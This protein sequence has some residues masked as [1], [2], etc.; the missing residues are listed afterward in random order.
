MKAQLVNL[1]KEYHAKLAALEKKNEPK[2]LEAKPRIKELAN[3]LHMYE[4]ENE[5]PKGV[6]V[7]ES[8]GMC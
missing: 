2:M 6:L 4:S 8:P 3:V 7:A 5:L 1:K